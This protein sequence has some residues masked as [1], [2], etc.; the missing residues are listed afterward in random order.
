MNIV[1]INPNTTERITDNL[2]GQARQSLPSHWHV[3]GLTASTGPSVVKSQPDIEYARRSVGELCQRLPENTD[4]V[5]LGVSLDIGLHDLRQTLRQP[6][7]GL[8]ESALRMAT[9]RHTPVFAVTVGSHMLRHYIQMTRRYG[10][11][12]QAVSWHAVDLKLGLTPNGLEDA[13][14]QY[15]L[16]KVEQLT[17]QTP[18]AIVIFVGAVLAGLSQYAQSKLPRATFIE[19]MNAVCADIAVQRFNE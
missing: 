13:E 5:I 15:L 12:G 9:Q 2:V 3:S 14:C 11:L 17:D 19:P 18:D 1:V 6:V 7:F 4:I 10:T 8:S 16:E